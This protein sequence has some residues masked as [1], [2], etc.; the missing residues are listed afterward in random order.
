MRSD[1]GWSQGQFNGIADLQRLQF[2]GVIFILLLVVRLKLGDLILK[3]LGVTRSLFQRFKLGIPLTNSF[4][5]G[6]QFGVDLI[7]A[8][9]GNKRTVQPFHYL[10][11]LFFSK[12]PFHQLFFRHVRSSF[13]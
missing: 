12:A 4:L 7:E 2:I 1:T 13:L 11:G 6:A 5:C 3:G 9:L 8:G 10:I